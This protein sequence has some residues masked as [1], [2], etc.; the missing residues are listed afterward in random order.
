MA[1][2]KT[3]K[4]TKKTAAKA[5]KTKAKKTA[6][7][8][9]KAPRASAR[10]R[11]KKAI[12]TPPPP[13]PPP[14]PTGAVIAAPD[15]CVCGHAPEEHGRDSANPSS[16]SCLECDDCV[17]YEADANIEEETVAENEV[18]DVEDDDAADSEP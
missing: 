9:T 16:T 2:K 5:K 14:A 15:T 7:K 1:K 3:K 17:A 8:K 11:L 18:V 13:A 12:P 6:A 4:V 10:G